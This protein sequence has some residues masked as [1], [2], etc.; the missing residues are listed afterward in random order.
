MKTFYLIEAIQFFVGAIIIVVNY[1]LISHHRKPL[2][3]YTFRNEPAAEKSFI[4]LTN[5]IYFL[6]FIPVLFFGISIIPPATYNVAKHIQYTIYFE[7]GLIFAIGTLH[8][9][10]MAIS[11]KI[12]F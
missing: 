7:A 10:L 8:F 2:I 11:T 9:F 4:N 3:D 12:K 1:F 6:V 5:I